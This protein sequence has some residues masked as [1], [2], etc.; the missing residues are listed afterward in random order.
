MQGSRD[1][2]E[3]AIVFNCQNEELVGVLCRG[4]QRAREVA[5]LIVVGGPQYRVGSHRQFVLLARTLARMGFPVLRF[6]YRGM[7]DSSGETRTFETVNEDITAA[8]D[9]LLAHAR[10]PRGVVIFGLCD[11]ASAALMYCM[12][13]K[14]VVG[15][16]LANPWVRTPQG[17]ARAHVRHYYTARLFQRSFWTKVFK[18]EFDLGRGFLEYV[19]AIR[20]AGDTRSSKS[21]GTEHGFISR[22]LEGMT[23]FTGPIQLLLSEQDLTAQE[24]SELCKADRSWGSAIAQPSITVTAVPQADHT[25]STRASLDFAS[26]A[27]LDW[28]VNNERRLCDSCQCNG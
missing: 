25:F 13:D 12:G 23:G 5:V 28:L 22:M 20:L 16:V 24:F 21:G 27:V 17:Q 6:D 1:F 14:R 15:L 8:L 26:R 11:A 4:T 7:G 9:A 2:Q 10:S 18:G 3:T 19:R